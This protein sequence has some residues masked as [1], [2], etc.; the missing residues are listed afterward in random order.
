MA[1][2][3]IKEIDNDFCDL[4]SFQCHSLSVIHLS[5]CSH[6]TTTIAL[7]LRLHLPASG[8]SLVVE[9]KKSKSRKEV[10]PTT[11]TAQH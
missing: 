8:L 6:Y 7:L 3:L 1:L 5:L 4:L 11:H 10:N 9:M 2:L